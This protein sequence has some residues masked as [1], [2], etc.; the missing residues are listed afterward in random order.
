MLGFCHIWINIWIWI[1]VDHRYTVAD[2]GEKGLLVIISDKN[3]LVTILA[4]EIF[5]VDIVIMYMNEL[6]I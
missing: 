6:P 5:D 1:A 2:P 4:H 3:T